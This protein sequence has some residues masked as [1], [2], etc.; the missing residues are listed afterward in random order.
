MPIS[1]LDLIEAVRQQLDDLGGDTGT[2]SAGYYAYWQEIDIGCLWKNTELV[3]YLN[4]TLRELGQRQPIQDGGSNYPI[5]LQ[6]GQRHYE[7]E[8]EIVRIESITRDSDGEALVK[9]TI[10]E[11]Q[12]VTRWHRHQRDYQDANWRTETGWPTHYLLDEQQ[13]LLT[14]YP[15]PVL[16]FVDTLR[17][18]V[19][20]TFIDDVTW[21]S[22]ARTTSPTAGEIADVPNHYFDALVAG[23]CA[24]A[25]R[26]RDAD[27]NAPKLAAECEA[28]FDRRVGT[29][30]SFLNLD[31]DARWSDMPGDITP[32]TYF[33]R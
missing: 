23:V 29:P 12:A 32:R 1:A 26:K 16:T 15:T 13:G 9:S 6:A 2:P 20:R 3:R 8:P 5:R 14:V 18:S 4:Q 25:Y 28:E 11:M 17:L 19:W 21:T 31:A 27:A 10:H 30:R 33:A 7:L 24:R 22:I